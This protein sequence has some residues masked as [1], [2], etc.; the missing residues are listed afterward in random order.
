[1]GYRTALNFISEEALKE[2]ART[3]EDWLLDEQSNSDIEEEVARLRDLMSF[4]VLESGAENDYDR[5]TESVREEFNGSWATIEL[6]DL[7]RHWLKSY[8]ESVDAPLKSVHAGSECPRQS[9]FSAYAILQDD[10]FVVPD[11]TQDVRFNDN[12]AVK[13]DQHL[14]FYAGAP[15]ISPDGH[16]I[17]TLAVMANTPRPQG[18]GSDGECFLKSQAS[19]VMNLLVERRENIMMNSSDR[20]R[21]ASMVNAHRLYHS[22]SEMSDL[23]DGK[24]VCSDSDESTINTLDKT[25]VIAIGRISDEN[26]GKRSRASSPEPSVNRKYEDRIIPSPKQLQVILPSPFTEGVD[27]DE[28]LVQLV[29]AMYPG[30]TL[31]TKSSKSLEGYFLT[32]T[33]EQMSRYNTHVVSL[34]RNNDVAGLKKYYSDHGRD[35]LECFNRFGEGLLNMSCRRGFTEMTEFLLSPEIQLPVRMRDDYG[36]TPLHDA[37]WNPGPQLSICQWL[38]QKEPSLFLVADDRGFTPFQYARKSDWNIWRQFLFDNREY[39]Q[40]LSQPDIASR[41]CCK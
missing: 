36:R 15:L 27:P 38:M 39:L 14:R 17:G 5:I 13:G 8:A 37:C 35:A 1:M 30:V 16:K 18:L 3:T 31:K 41:F 32:I 4:C 7:G 24:S 2:A 28:Y 12:P 6:V 29:N 33:E 9:S 25:S 23:S 20:K 11:T 40:P 21:N 22:E 26:S 34:G 19:A 10:V